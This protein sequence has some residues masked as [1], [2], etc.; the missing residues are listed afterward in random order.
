M[1]DIEKYIGHLI[2]MLKT[3]FGERL[4]YVGLQGSYLRGEAN[5]N[6]DIDIMVV[7]DDLSISDLSGYR[8][9]IESMDHFDKSCGFI[10]SKSD[11]LNWNSLEICHLLHSTRD[12]FGVLSDFVPEY[13]DED[14]RN[15]VKL[16]LNN[17]YHEICHSYIHADSMTNI[18]GL[19]LAYKGVFFI[20]QNLHYLSS[21]I[22]PSTKSEL[23]S[24][25]SGKNYD[26][27][28]RSV[29]ISSGAEFDFDDSFE[30]LFSWCR[31]TLKTL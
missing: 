12:Y 21:G 7:I 11:L 17:L 15:Y 6:S 2:D 5:D 18:S 16:S 26:V 8:T 1:V 28:K 30:L 23:L 9:V 29:D 10:C 19:R 27:L 4:L 3:R 22:F 31:E 14:V 24:L 13:C 25:I 20:I